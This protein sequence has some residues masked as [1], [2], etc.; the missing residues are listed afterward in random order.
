MLD[1]AAE[2]LGDVE[3]EDKGVLLLQMG[4]LAYLLEQLRG[5]QLGLVVM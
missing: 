1:V 2:G 5:Q 3:Q 4:L